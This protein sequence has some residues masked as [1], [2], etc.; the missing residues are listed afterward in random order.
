[1]MR[2]TR[3]ILTA[4]LVAGLLAVLLTACKKYD[5]PV[6]TGVKP[7]IEVYADDDI[8]SAIYDGVKA[9][10]GEDR[11]DQT[12][13]VEASAY[14]QSGALLTKYTPGTYRLVYTSRDEEGQEAQSVE[15]VLTVKPA[16]TTGPVI[17]GAQDMV[18]EVGT[19]VSYRAGVTAVDDVDGTVQLQID[20]GQ[21]VLSQPGQYPVVYTA[22]DSRGNVTTVTVTLTVSAPAEPEQPKDPDME[23]P[24]DVLVKP[25]TGLNVTEEELNVVVDGVLAKI[26]TPGMSQYEQARAIFDYVASHITYIGPSDSSSWVNGAYIGLTQGRGDCYNYFAACKALLTRLEIPNID[27]E[28]VGGESQHYWSIINVGEGWYHY[29]ACPHPRNYPVD[30]FM[31]D[32]AE[33]RAY[34]EFCTPV[35]K[36][37]Y[38]YDYAACPVVVEGTP[39]EVPAE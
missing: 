32:E 39:E 14:D 5:P 21:V 9:V 18:T 6:I 7:A 31:M 23:D 3:Q 30:S 28:R 1:M 19:A 17:E 26:C 37:Y 24:S 16:D 20:A 2:K 10:G 36:N 34:S 29:D 35:R 25:S 22:A 13:P 33:A 4:L 27:L 8:F 12:F 15:S 38:I 11:P